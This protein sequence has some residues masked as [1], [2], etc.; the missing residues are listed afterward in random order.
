LFIDSNGKISLITKKLKI[1]P[2]GITISDLSNTLIDGELVDSSNITTSDSVKPKNITTSDSV[3]PKKFTFLAFDI[4]F[5]KG[6]DQRNTDFY[7]LD[8]MGFSEK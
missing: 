8:E 1:K 6:K 3:K 4:L 7:D 2:T 5:L